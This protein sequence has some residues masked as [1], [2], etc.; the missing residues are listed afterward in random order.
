MFIVPTSWNRAGRER[1]P[2]DARHGDDTV[3]ERLPQ[4]FEDR[5]RELR[6]LV[7]E[8]HA[9]VC[10]RDLAGPGARPAPD[11]RG[12]GGAVV[13]RANRGNGDERSPVRQEPRDRVDPGHLERLRSGEQRQHAG[14]A[15]REHRLTRAGRAGE[16]QVVGPGSRD[17]ERATRA[18]LPADVGEVRGLVGRQLVVSERLE[19][20]CRDLPAEVGDGLGEVPHGY[21]LDARESDL[22]SRLHRAHDPAQ[23]GP[24]GALRDGQGARDRS[25]A[26]VERE[27]PDRRMVGK[28]LRRELSRGGE[29]G[30]RDRE[31]EPGAL[32]AE[33]RRRGVHGD[34]PVERPFEGCGDDAAPDAVLR[35]LASPVGQPHDRESRDARLEVRLHL[36]PARVE[37]DER[38][39][40]RAS[41]HLPTIAR[42]RSRM[43][44]AFAPRWL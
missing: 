13:R 42:R 32:L 37:P 26:P 20:G 6:Q 43:V 30:E 15:S 9:S 17:L 24:A 25:D 38:M 22:G 35:L 29:H 28:A 33:R 18:L 4:G 44:T 3:L 12:G 8:E 10:E 27:L 41:E 36:D 7:E 2:A 5:P 11:D 19:A 39:R 23:A 14:Q 31:V 21:R 16:Q 34:P 1:V 40:D